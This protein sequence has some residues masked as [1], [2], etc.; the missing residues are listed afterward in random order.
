MIGP[1]KE[2]NK[3]VSKGP[4]VYDNGCNKAKGVGIDRRQMETCEYL[5]KLKMGGGRRRARDDIALQ[6]Q[7]KGIAPFASLLRHRVTI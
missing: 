5:I 2:I 3:V 6:I 1:N 4:T 7:I